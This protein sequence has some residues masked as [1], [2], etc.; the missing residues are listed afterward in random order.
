MRGT[1]G[2]GLRIFLV[3]EDDSLKRLSLARYERLFRGDREERL[4]EYAGMRV[5]FAMVVLELA[6]RKPVEIIKIEY[7]FFHFDSQGRINQAE[8]KR[9]ARLAMEMLAPLTKDQKGSDVIDARHR[10]ARK[11]YDNIYRWRPSREIEDAIVGAI[12]GEDWR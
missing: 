8:Q 9:E 7:S 6:D 2:I 3:N 1:M 5:R 10:F 11:Q 12:F 4:R